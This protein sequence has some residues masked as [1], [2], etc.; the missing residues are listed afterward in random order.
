MT[1]G[2]PGLIYAIVAFAVYHYSVKYNESKISEFL[3]YYNKAIVYLQQSLK[4]RR[5]TDATLLTILQLA[6]IEVSPIH[7]YDA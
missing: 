4:S 5:H 7:S 6:A 3:S 1:E 2:T